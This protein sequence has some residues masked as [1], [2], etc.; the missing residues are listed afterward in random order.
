MFVLSPCTTFAHPVQVEGCTRETSHHLCFWIHNNCRYCNHN[1][2]LTKEVSS[3]LLAHVMLHGKM[4]LNA[5]TRMP[6][7]KQVGFR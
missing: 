5:G 2:L 6:E 4:S 3:I 7:N 1:A